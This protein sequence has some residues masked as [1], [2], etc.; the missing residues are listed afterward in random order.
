MR[1][2]VDSRLEDDVSRLMC[3]APIGCTRE[4]S[5]FRVARFARDKLREMHADNDEAS[6]FDLGYCGV[7]ITTNGAIVLH[8]GTGS[9]ETP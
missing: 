9:W 5:C 2:R 7:Q 6:G 1:P 3:C 8:P 4:H